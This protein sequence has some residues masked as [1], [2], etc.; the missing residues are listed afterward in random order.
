M[1]MFHVPF[2]GPMLRR[3]AVAR[4]CRTL[5][6]LLASGV[7]LVDALRILASTTRNAPIRELTEGMMSTIIRGERLARTFSEG[8]IF[9]PMV[10]Q[11]ITVGEEVGRLDEILLHTAQHYEKEIDA[12]VD[13]MASIIEPVLILILGL[14]VGGILI[15]MYLPLFSLMDV[16]R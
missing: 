3:V 6:T 1:A 12:Q 15:S 5:G 8:T 9:P 10:V 4:F 7:R 11:M 14:V 2:V 13:A 16:V